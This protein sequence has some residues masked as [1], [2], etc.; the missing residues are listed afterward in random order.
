MSPLPFSSPAVGFEQPFEMLQ[1]CHERVQ[2]SLD[3]LLR[4]QAHAAVHG[5]DAQARSAAGDVLRYFDLAAP[6]HHEDEELHILPRLRASGNLELAALA[7]ALQADHAAMAAAWAALRS[8]LLALSSGSAQT[9]DAAAC[10]HFAA[11]YAGHVE[12]EESQAY[13]SARLALTV[14]A[15]AAMGTEM[16][17]RRK[18]RAGR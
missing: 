7:D 9:L 17:A 14:Q 18:A 11:L 1:A 5:A 13:P 3:L 4:L 8:G 2:R 15:V 16:A 6:A 12:R 10:Q